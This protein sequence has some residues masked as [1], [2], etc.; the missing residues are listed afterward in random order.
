MIAVNMREFECRREALVYFSSL[1]LLTGSLCHYYVSLLI[2]TVPTF[3]GNMANYKFKVDQRSDW[4]FDRQNLDSPSITTLLYYC[5][6]FKCEYMNKSKGEYL[7]SWEE[8]S[9]FQV[10]RS[11]L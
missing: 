11:L 6:V 10:L 1:H 7:I 2:L 8:K 9:Y 4:R 3:L 5:K